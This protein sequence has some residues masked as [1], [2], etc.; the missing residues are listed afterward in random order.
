MWRAQIPLEIP[1]FPV[2]DLFEGSP[3]IHLEI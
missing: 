2:V 1:I 3:Q